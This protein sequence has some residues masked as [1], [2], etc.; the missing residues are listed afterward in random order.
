MRG[1]RGAGT[2][3]RAAPATERGDGPGRAPEHGPR[4]PRTRHPRL[5]PRRLSERAAHTLRLLKAPREVEDGAEDLVSRNLA[6]QL[7]AR[8]ALH[9]GLPAHYVEPTIPKTDSASF[10]FV[11]GYATEV[12]RCRDLSLL[13][14]YLARSVW[15]QILCLM[16]SHHLLSLGAPFGLFVL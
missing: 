10:F 14:K 12:A 11:K 9:P 1:R 8:L 7:N 6:L 5:P 3:G 4:S 13:K 16:N 2:G 15:W